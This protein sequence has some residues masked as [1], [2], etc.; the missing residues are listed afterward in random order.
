MDIKLRFTIPLP[1]G[2]VESLD[3]D[4]DTPLE[5]YISDGKLVVT[6]LDDEDFGDLVCTGDCVNCNMC[7]DDFADDDGFDDCPTGECDCENCEYFCKICG[8]CTYDD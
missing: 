8:E 2:L 6:T 5:A 7:D 1:K 4:E 3:V